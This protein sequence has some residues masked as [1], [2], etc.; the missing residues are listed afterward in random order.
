MFFFFFF[1]AS[2][3]IPALVQTIFKCRLISEVGAEQ[4]LLDITS[5]KQ[6]LLEIPTYSLEGKKDPS[7]VPSRYSKHVTKEMGRA[8]KLLK[9]LISPPEAMVATYLAI[10]KEVSEH[11]LARIMELKGIPKSEQQQMLDQY[12]KMLP[13]RLAQEKAD[14][15]AKE[16]AA[17]AEDD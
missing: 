1:F 4:M 16:A 8:E 13:Q 15:E 5:I 6:V 2:L 7:T 12:K 9:I 10:A 14:K 17:A 3:C 11:R